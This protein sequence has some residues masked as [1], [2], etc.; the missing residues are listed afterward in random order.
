MMENSRR[1]SNPF[2]KS[3]ILNK[4]IAEKKETGTMPIGYSE[5]SE[6]MRMRREADATSRNQIISKKRLEEAI[7]WNEIL[8]DPV[9]KRRKRR[10]R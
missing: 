7:I 4:T 6:P 10:L 9:S 8:G 2:M 5:K 3:K 1:N